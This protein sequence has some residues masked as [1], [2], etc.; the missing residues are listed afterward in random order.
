MTLAQTYSWVF[1]AIVL[2]NQKE[3]ASMKTIEQAAD[4]INHAIPTQREISASIK[5]LTA[6]KWIEKDGK[7]IRLIDIGNFIVEKVVNKPVGLMKVWDRITEEIAD[8]GIDNSQQIDPK[9]LSTE[10]A[11]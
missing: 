1:Y 3:A 10:Q 4:A 7:K 8:M 5:W 11:V 2:A 6:K 9:N